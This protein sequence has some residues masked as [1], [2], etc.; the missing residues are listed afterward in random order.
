MKLYGISQK[1]EGLDK[2][3]IFFDKDDAEQELHHY[4]YYDKEYPLD[5]DDFSI[6]EIEVR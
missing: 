5:I 6:V 4:V 1:Y 2:D 3:W